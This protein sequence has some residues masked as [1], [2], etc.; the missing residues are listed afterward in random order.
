MTKLAKLKAAAEAGEW[1]KAISIANKF[2]RLGKIK[3]DVERAH[4]AFT[5]PGFARQIGRDPDALI[6]SGIAALTSAYGL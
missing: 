1:A 2:P 6:A 5:N 4:M 3:V